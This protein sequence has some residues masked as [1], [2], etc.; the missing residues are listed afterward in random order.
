MGLKPKDKITLQITGT[1]S[2]GRGVGKVDNFVVFVQDACEGDLV[3]ATVFTVHKTYATAGVEKVIEPSPFRQTSFCGVATQCGGCPLSHVQYEKQLSIKKQ[4]VTDA[5]SRIGGFDLQDAAVSDTVGM[6]T[7][8]CYR[9]KMVFPIGTKENRVCGG[10]YAPR[11]HDIVPLSACGVGEQAATQIM[12]CV[13]RW[14]NEKEIAPYNEKTGQGS[15]RRV[16]VR[17]GYHSKELMVV[18]SSNTK[19]IKDLE[20]LVASLCKTNLVGYS[21]KSIVL[22][23]NSKKNNLV[24]GDENITLWGSSVIYDTLM[25]LTFSISPHSFYQVNPVQTQTLYQ[26]AIDLAGLTKEQTVLDIYCGIG[27]ISLC[28]AQYAKQVVGVEI[29]E[30]AIQDAEENA[31]RN[32]VTNAS[33]YCGAAENIVPKLIENGTRPD[34]VI[35]DPPRKGSDEKTLSAILSVAP[36]RIVYVSCNPSTLARDTKFLANGGYRISKV[37][38]VDMFPHTVHVEC[39]VLLCRT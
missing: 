8:F 35:L 25:G 13:V 34:V 17:T 18:I 26:T 6:K 12:Q 2:D 31:R 7:P 29:V 36:E 38:P 4:V 37:V 30:S 32:N 10:F 21:L 24:L 33:F 22:N 3:E 39:C 11:S 20:S 5:L 14:M 9:N 16:F 1:A 23:V 15:V 28:A 27:T 19:K